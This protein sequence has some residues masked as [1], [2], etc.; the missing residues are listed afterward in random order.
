MLRGGKPYSYVYLF[1]FFY[2]QISV[3]VLRDGGQQIWLIAPLSPAVTV[4]PAAVEANQPALYLTVAA[5]P[6]IVF[7]DGIA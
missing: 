6:S 1:S 2:L 3:R 5:S 4:N 7:Y